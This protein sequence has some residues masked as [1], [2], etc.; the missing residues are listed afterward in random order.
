MASLD[1]Q[2][3]PGTTR[4]QG[5]QFR[6]GQGMLWLVLESRSH[7]RATADFRLSPL[8]PDNQTLKAFL[9]MA[10][11]HTFYDPA[12][13]D[14]DRQNGEARLQGTTTLDAPLPSN[15]LVTP[16][17]AV[18]YFGCLI[19]RRNTTIRIPATCHLFVGLWDNT[20]DPPR[21]DWISADEA[22]T[23]SAIVRGFAPLVT[24]RRYKIFAFTDRGYQYLSD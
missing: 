16:N 10:G 23:V 14:W 13:C 5:A 15:R 3:I 18:E 24:E 7:S 19:A 12:F 20:S 9:T 11:V 21:P 6:C 8:M 4:R 2:T 1:T 17:R 22:F